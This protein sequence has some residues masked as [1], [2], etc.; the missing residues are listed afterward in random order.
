MREGYFLVTGLKVRIHIPKPIVN[1]CRPS[2]HV[3]DDLEVTVL[4]ADAEAALEEVFPLSPGKNN[5]K[6]IVATDAY[7]GIVIVL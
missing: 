2:L 7:S 3:D 6:A 5:D 4:T 1:A